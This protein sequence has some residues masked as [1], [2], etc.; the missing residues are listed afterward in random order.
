MSH[1]VPAYVDELEV[2]DAT[3][4]KL[5]SGCDKYISERIWTVK[6]KIGSLS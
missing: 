4:A 2:H 6:S 1:G 3:I 5:C